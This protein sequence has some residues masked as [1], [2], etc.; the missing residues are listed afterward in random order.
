MN[1]NHLYL[2]VIYLSLD[3]VVHNPCHTVKFHTFRLC[4]LCII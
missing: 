4:L 3:V 1:Y 2:T